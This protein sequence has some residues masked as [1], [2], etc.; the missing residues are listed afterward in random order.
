MGIV[1]HPPPKKTLTKPNNPCF[2][3]QI[4]HI[5]YHPPT[6]PPPVFP[7][8]VGCPTLKPTLACINDSKDSWHLEKHRGIVRNN[9]S[10][11]NFL[12]GKLNHEEYEFIEKWGK[13][14][15]GIKTSPWKRMNIL[16]GKMMERCTK[17]SP[18][19]MEKT[20]ELWRV[21]IMLRVFSFS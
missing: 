3:F 14:F 21:W 8:V 6:T 5:I 10:E 12:R 7:G 1:F 9:K 16:M 19:A 4:A 11:G 2:F 13:I 17:D 20:L 15:E 18:G